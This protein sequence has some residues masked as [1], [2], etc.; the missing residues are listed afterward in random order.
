M[1]K[2]KQVHKNKYSHWYSN[3]QTNYIFDLQKSLLSEIQLYKLNDEIKIYK[4]VKPD[5][6]YLGNTFD[7]F[8]SFS[9]IKVDKSRGLKSALESVCRHDV[10]MNFQGQNFLYHTYKVLG[11]IRETLEA[12][13][14]S[15]DKKFQK[16]TIGLYT[17]HTQTHRSRYRKSIKYAFDS[18]TTSQGAELVKAILHK[19]MY[20]NEK[21]TKHYLS[22]IAL[23]GVDNFKL[24]KNGSS[25]SKT[26]K[27]TLKMFMSGRVD[28][29][30]C[31][32]SLLAV[33]YYYLRFKMRI[34]SELA[35]S[36]TKGIVFDIFGVAKKYESSELL[37]NLY[38]KEVIGE[39]IIFGFSTKTQS[40]CL[41]QR[42]RYRNKI[43][44]HQIVDTKKFPMF[45]I[46]ETFNNPLRL[47]TLSTPSELL[48]EIV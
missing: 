34:D 30:D 14:L 26:L 36:T 40:I 12:L 6:I 16:G 43:I 15:K 31:A 46:D 17:R 23:F 25:E 1:S 13:R 42:A 9:E 38:V 8:N 22:I 48:Q 20:L 41:S 33:L 11:F 18:E 27:R 44:E 7:L 24:F 39:N 3:D 21:L 37:K 2:P 35:L 19:N 10:V 32:N 29:E 45:I 4:Y 28:K 47:H 5:L